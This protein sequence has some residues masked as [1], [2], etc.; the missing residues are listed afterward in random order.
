M[1]NLFGIQWITKR[2][3]LWTILLIVGKYMD[4]VLRCYQIC[5]GI[6]STFGVLHG[7]CQRK[8]EDLEKKNKLNYEE[9][10]IK[11]I[12]MYAL[13]D[14]QQTAEYLNIRSS[15]YVEEWMGYIFGI[16]QCQKGHGLR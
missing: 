10:C 1:D 8:L 6:W 2:Y 4:L 7:K 9:W 3:T 5:T 15:T 11:G 12:L 16:I 13:G 14:Y